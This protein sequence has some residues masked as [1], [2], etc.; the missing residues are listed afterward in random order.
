MNNGQSVGITRDGILLYDAKLIGDMPQLPESVNTMF[1]SGKTT[2]V[3][4]LFLDEKEAMSCFDSV[5]LRVCDQRWKEQT[6]QVMETIGNRHPVFR[7]AVMP[8]FG[9]SY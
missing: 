2:S 6:M 5:N 4:A 3:V 7:F 1:W 9:I 8:D